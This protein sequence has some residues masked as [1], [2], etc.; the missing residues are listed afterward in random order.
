M[1]KTSCLLGWMHYRPVSRNEDLEA[2]RGYRE[3]KLQREQH[4]GSSQSR[5]CLEVQ[6]A[7][8]LPAVFGSE[9]TDVPRCKVAFLVNTAIV[10][11]ARR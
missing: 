9:T 3:G 1:W 8:V 7:V 10:W 11:Q 5:C 6:Q 4:H 2:Q